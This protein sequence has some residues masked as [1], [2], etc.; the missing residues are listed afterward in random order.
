ML[1][2]LPGRLG[3]RLSFECLLLGDGGGDM[4]FSTPAVVAMPEYRWLRAKRSLSICSADTMVWVP[5]SA[6]GVPGVL[7]IE[8]ELMLASGIR[9]SLTLE[10]I[11]S[12]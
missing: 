10:D 2:E 12:D 7:A 11:V 4:D 5:S 1:P 6:I 8:F 9:P 3:V